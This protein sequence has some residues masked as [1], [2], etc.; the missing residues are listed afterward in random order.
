M[1]KINADDPQE[2]AMSDVERDRIF[3]TMN[4]TFKDESRC[5]EAMETI[6]ND[7]HAAYGVTSHFW[8]R[9][10]D[11]KS[12][13]VVEQYADGKALSQALRRFTFARVNFFRSIKVDSVSIYGGVSFGAKVIFSALRPTHMNYYGGY[14]K[15]VAVADGAGI[16]GFERDRVFVATNA[17]FRDEAKCHEAMGALVEHAHAEPGTSSHFWTRSRDGNGLLLLEQYVNQKALM[18]HM[19]AHQALRADFL[20]SVEVEDVTVYGAG[21]ADVGEMLAP[22][23]PTYMSYYG[24]YSK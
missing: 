17:T 20:E 22:L 9:S 18:G 3:V 7:A 12:L 11:G 1:D 14:S 8:F 24:G 10:E 23:D 15:P 5:R 16:Q 2:V 19:A 21:A 4:A 13:F 6:V